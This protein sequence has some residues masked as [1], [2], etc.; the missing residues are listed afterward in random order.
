MKSKVIHNTTFMKEICFK[1]FGQ[2]YVIELLLSLVEKPK[3]FNEL[4]KEHD[5]N[6]STLQKR[7][8]VMEQA[9]FITKKPCTDDAR[10]FFYI[11]TQRGV[12]MADIL[13]QLKQSFHNSQK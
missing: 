3:G 9:K 6:T 11:I 5:I 12:M 4:Q 7:L 10:S 2:K 8:V 13:L 1:I